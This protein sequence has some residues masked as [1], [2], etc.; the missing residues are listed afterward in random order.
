MGKE[1][2]GSWILNGNFFK[3]PGHV[4][5]QGFHRLDTFRIIFHLSRVSADPH[6]PIT[7]TRDDHLV[8]EEEEVH[9]AK[10]MGGACPADGNHGCSHLAF[11]QV[12]IEAGDERTA[13]DEGFH[14][15][16]HV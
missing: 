14:V 9:R 1:I 16:R 2:W 7:G 6:I 11:K 15:G 3:K 4:L 10:N 13:F 5:A 12:S 8:D